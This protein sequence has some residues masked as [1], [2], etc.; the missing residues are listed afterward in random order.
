[1]A[2]YSQKR[3]VRDDLTVLVHVKVVPLP[4]DYFRFE[5][6]LE[7]SPTSH[8]SMSVFALELNDDWIKYGG[9]VRNVMPPKEKDWGE[10][11]SVK[12]KM[13]WVAYY[14]TTGL[15]IIE[16]APRSAII[17]GENLSFSF[18]AKGLPGIGLFWAEGWAP[19]SFSREQKDSLIR[20]GYDWEKSRALDE[21]Y[22]KGVTVVRRSPPNP[23]VHLTF[24]DTLLSYTRQSAELGWLAPLTGLG[25]H[26]D[27][28]CDEDE[29]PDDGVTKNIDKRLQKAKK[30]LSKGDSL[31]ARKELEKLVEKLER[32][33]KRS[34]EQEKKHKQEKKEKRDDVILTSE[35]YA[36]LKYNT[37]YLIDRLPDRK[38]KK[39]SKEKE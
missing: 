33:W 21:N 19:W 6:S 10:F 2:A 7:N 8:Q 5:Y 26:R 15:D 17:P 3:I 13:S 27:D 28:D 18:Q 14:D 32:T 31:K 12:R 34:Q 11:P 20:E 39:G 25:R 23:F 35:A 24:L 16:R 22:S 9:S 1:M 37:E 30:E 36:L 29:R 38:P 4:E